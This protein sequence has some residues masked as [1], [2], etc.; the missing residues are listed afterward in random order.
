LDGTVI[1]VVMVAFRE[2]TG[3][4]FGK[5][6]VLSRAPNNK[7]GRAIWVCRCACTGKELPVMGGHLA[8]GKRLLLRE[9]NLEAV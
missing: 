3:M 8:S 7:A 9:N 2:L 4:R 5:L 6:T 1:G